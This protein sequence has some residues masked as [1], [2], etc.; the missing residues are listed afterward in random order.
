MGDLDFQVLLHAHGGVV[1]GYQM[2]GGGV[3]TH[4]AVQVGTVQTLT[5]DPG[6][7]GNWGFMQ[8]EK[9]LQGCQVDRVVRAGQ[10]AE[11]AQR[12]VIRHV[13]LGCPCDAI[14]VLVNTHDIQHRSLGLQNV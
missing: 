1:H 9:L 13:L 4:R 2:C 5:E 14:V 8:K 7:R 11:E 6:A 10:G 3:L 12:V